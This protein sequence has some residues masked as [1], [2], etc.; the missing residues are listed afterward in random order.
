MSQ[1]ISPAKDGINEGPASVPHVI[2][3][4]HFLQPDS[5]AWQRGLARVLDSLTGIRQLNRL[6]KQHQFAGLAV[7][8]FLTKLREVAHWDIGIAASDLARIPKSG[9]LILVANHPYGGLEGVLLASILT[10]L[11][12]DVK[13]LANQAL[14]IFPELAPC[15]IFT[16]P[17]K[18][19]ARGNLTSLRQCQQ[20]VADG[21]LL[22]IFPSGRVSYP[23]SLNDLLQGQIYDHPWDRFAVHLSQRYQCPIQPLFVAGHNRRRFYA[24]GLLYYRFRLLML[25]RELLAS[26]GKT[27][28]FHLQVQPFIANPSKDATMQI[29]SYRLL[30]YLQDPGYRQGWPDV[31][32]QIFAEIAQP[33][34]AALL[35]REIDALPAAQRLVRYKHFEVCVATQKQCPAVVEEIRRLREVCFREFDEGSG[36]PQDGDDFDAYYLQLFIF[37]RTSQQIIGAYRMGPTD[38]ILPQH[39][40]DGLYLSRMFAFSEQFI[41]RRQPCLEMGRSFVIRA[42][43]KSFH[44]LLLLFR[45]IAA[46]VTRN[47]QYQILYGTVSLSKQYNPLSV[48][49]M[50]RVLATPSE[51]VKARCAFVHPEHP[52]LSRFLSEHTLDIEE[53]DQL[54]RQIEPDG[55]GLPVL[56]RQYHQLGARFYTV[57]IDPN[58]A[59]TPGFLLSVDLKAAPYRQLKLF[60]GDAL[61]EYLGMVT[62]TVADGESGSSVLA[63]E[64]H[65]APAR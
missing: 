45:G 57:G 32:T 60:F 56:V 13:I 28:Q 25:V 54:I 14:Q 53:L 16:N 30:T 34:P 6:Y 46:F 29:D 40:V 42:K 37:D 44:A 39:G 1:H 5:P 18:P 64:K 38:Q 27:T 51:Q 58:F 47:P 23:R 41:N 22:V 19:N 65:G 36:Q 62:S 17:L 20:H 9:P 43:Q 49:L 59:S 52:E 12:S 4:R 50:S 61:S 26:Q 10:A 2:S 35:M 33:Q 21:G 24:L 55:K 7:A 63:V 8:E 15:F 11:R 31:E 48:W 3:L